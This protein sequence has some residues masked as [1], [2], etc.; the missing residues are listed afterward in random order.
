[1]G[2]D[3]TVVYPVVDMKM[4][5]PHP[6]PLVVHAKVDGNRLH[7]ELLGKAKPVSVEFKRELVKTIPYGRKI[8]EKRELWAK[9]VVVKQHGIRGYRI[10]RERVLTF[11]NGHK[12]VETNNDFYPPTAEI[13]EVPRNFDVSLLP[14]LPA[15]DEDEGEGSDTSA[16][17][18][19]AASAATAPMPPPGWVPPYVGAPI[20]TTFPAQQP[21]PGAPPAASTTACTTPDCTPPAI[22]TALGGGDIRV[23]VAPGAHAPTTAQAK[24]PK[25][26]T[27]RR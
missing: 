9:R 5:N 7:V 10:K 1:M 16:A 11:H 12:K 6:F 20:P 14:P 2:L 3:A 26:M 8:E 18:A 25:T 4:R 23:A 17:T 13:Y 19:A 21:P 24:P 15:F 22:P 27:I